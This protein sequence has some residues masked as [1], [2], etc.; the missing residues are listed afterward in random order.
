MATDVR[1]KVLPRI[2]RQNV[3]RIATVIKQHVTRLV[4]SIASTR[5]RSLDDGVALSVGRWSDR[6]T[7][8]DRSR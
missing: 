8:R 3:F 2:R 5:D 7:T 1:C 4:F 6:G